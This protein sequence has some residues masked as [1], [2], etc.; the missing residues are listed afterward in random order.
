MSKCRACGQVI[1]FKPHPKNPEKL[2]PFDDDGE[3]H[4]ARCSGGKAK[5]EYNSRN[6]IMCKRCEELPLFVYPQITTAGERLTV[7]CDSYHRWHIPMT[8]KN[9]LLINAREDQVKHF[10]EILECRWQKRS[11][12]FDDIA[13]LR[14]WSHG[15][16]LCETYAQYFW[17]VPP[18]VAAV[19]SEFME[20]QT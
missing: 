13:R 19:L 5:K 8:P 17:P 6:E 11:P 12:Y 3:L 1:A 15:R 14:A 9:R 16:Y 18:E 2:A 4:F 7:M 20:A 10:Q